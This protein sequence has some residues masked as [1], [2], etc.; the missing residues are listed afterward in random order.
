MSEY[1][2]KSGDTLWSICK[3]FFKISE[4]TEIRDRVNTVAQRNYLE[5]P[6]SIFVGQKLDM[7]IG[8]EFYEEN[9]ENKLDYKEGEFFAFAGFANEGKGGMVSAKNNYEET[10]GIYSLDCA[11]RETMDPK[12]VSKIFKEAPELI[13]KMQF[14]DMTFTNGGYP[15]SFD[16]EKIMELGKDPAHNI[17]K[18][19]EMGYTGEGVAVAIIDW[20]L[21]RHENL[22]DVNGEDN[23]Q[24]RYT[25]MPNSKSSL[26]AMHGS[27]VASLL[28]GKE[29]G[30]APN[31]NVVYCSASSNSIEEQDADHIAAFK[32]ILEHNKNNP[33][34]PIRVVSMS[35]PVNTK[36]SE[37]L[38]EQLNQSGTWVLS[39]G[40][41]FENFGYLQRNDPM[42]DPNDF[43]NYSIAHE[44]SGNPDVL[45]INSG[46]RTVA[47]SVDSTN[48][49]HD[50]RASASWSIPVIA[51]L[52]TLACQADS[53]M[54]PERFV[55]LARETAQEI[56]INNN[57][58]G[59]DNYGQTQIAK[60]IDAETLI[61]KIIE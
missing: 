56:E 60:I 34:N 23:T 11:S 32:H 25:E 18:I 20:I 12:L 24:I 36:E 26:E 8:R 5:S 50:S 31:A 13:K 47:E 58:E 3:N 9:S 37:A 41:F 30:V 54:T 53:S 40:E 17:R 4:N 59:S 27:S 42:G 14:D 46:N 43:E 48:Y 35:A 15:D 7:R 16:P 19:Q 38:V 28:F 49:R 10:G 33:N 21:P 2:V 22:G 51:G 45:F 61:K 1:S 29:T 55:E 57:F 39:S 52:Y 6:N 44:G